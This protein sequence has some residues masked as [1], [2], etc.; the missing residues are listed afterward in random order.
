MIKDILCY[1]RY[2]KY[3]ANQGIKYHY[4]PL[5]GAPWIL[6]D[7]KSKDIFSKLKRTFAQKYKDEDIIAFNHY[8]KTKVGLFVNNPDLVREYTLI[9]NDVSK[10]L[11]FVKMPFSIGFILEHG[12][13]ALTLR[14][15][16]NE[17][18]RPANLK[19]ITPKINEL[20]KSK[21]ATLKKEL[22][23]DEKSGF[24]F[25]E[26]EMKNF[27]P[28]LFIDIVN[29]I[30]FGSEEF[31]MIDGM[32]LPEATYNLATDFVKLI[33]DPLHILSFGLLHDYGLH[34]RSR[35]FE[36]RGVRI[37]EK[38]F[39]VIKKRENRKDSELGVNMIDLM[40]KYNRTCKDKDKLS[41]EEMIANVVLLV[42]AGFDTVKS[43]T[44]SFLKIMSEEE[45]QEIVKTIQNREIPKIFKNEE[46]WEDNDN[47]E[48]S[49]YLNKTINEFLRMYGPSGISF[50]RLVMKDFKLGKYKF[51]KGDT[52]MMPF[53]TYHFNEN[54]FANPNKFDIERFSEEN[55]KN[56]RKLSYVPFY[57]G[58]RACIGK[59]LA[60]LLMRMIFTRLLDTFDIKS[61]G[62]EFELEF[63]FSQCVK[64]A[65]ILI[66]PRC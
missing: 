44:E 45:K 34:P 41:D 64:D 52:M 61:N 53:L 20:A 42:V 54:N 57:D 35:N 46:D 14:A 16:F 36:K 29:E 48:K 17:F 6:F 39:K 32:K 3:Y 28:E 18:F 59:Y 25:K 56:I 5:L 21:M 60:E 40:I 11:S 55:K 47:Y 50:E 31:P 9:E 37:Q 22:W 65:T 30:L 13:R 2:K 7:F 51:H 43:S 12:Q 26:Y 23:G 49:D 15:I 63:K 38:I 24:E 62:K 27:T 19:L 10:R 58:K 8:D 4:I 1:L 33:S 66:K